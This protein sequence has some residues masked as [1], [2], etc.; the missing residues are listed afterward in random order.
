MASDLICIEAENSIIEAEVSSVPLYR[1]KYQGV[2]WPTGDSGPTIAIGVDI[3]YTTHAELEHDWADRLPADMIAQ[4]HQGVSLKGERAHTAV[5]SG[6]F[7]KVRI[8]W[9]IAIK[10]FEEVEIPR[11]V[12]KTD[13]TYPGLE[14]LGPYCQG[15]LV[16]LCFN[17]GTQL[18]DAPGSN[19]RR[20]M[21]QI[22]EAILAGHPENVPD[23]L[24]QMKR[25][26]T[27]G[28]VARR[29]AE[30]KLFEKGLAEL[31]A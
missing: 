21:R 28:L 13:R 25:L 16:M 4:L 3:G 26:W 19:R 9:E 24:R 22:K 23:L 7:N 20:E 8:P 1:A 30:A 11:W 10:E 27:N 5:R 17:R 14:K 18:I 31:A 2:T 29:E 15:A 12:D 6:I